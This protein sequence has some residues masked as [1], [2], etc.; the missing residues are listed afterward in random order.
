MALEYGI[1]SGLAV[2]L[3]DQQQ[4]I[5]Y[6][7]NMKRQAKIAAEQKAKMFADD[8]DYNNA[9]NAH[10]NPL[11]KQY[12]MGKLM[13]IGKLIKENPGWETNPFARSR[14]KQ[15]IHDLKDNPA[16][17]RGNIS[18]GNF[19]VMMEFAGNPKN[20][21]IVNSPFW[22]E[23][24][25]EW[26][27]Y[28]EFGNQHGEEGLAKYGKQAFQFNSPESLIDVRQKGLEIG[29]KLG[30]TTQLTKGPGFGASKTFVETKKINDEAINVFRGPDAFHWEFSWDNLS[31]SEKNY[32]GADKIK[33]AS[34]LIKAGTDT[35]VTA[36][37]YIRP[38]NNNDSGNGGGYSA[39][40]HQILRSPTWQVNNSPTVKELSPL[41]NEDGKGNGILSTNEPLRIRA[42]GKNGETYWKT[43]DGF[44]NYPVAATRTNDYMVDG[45]GRVM[46]RFKVKVNLDSDNASEIRNMFDENYW[47]QFGSDRYEEMEAYSNVA[48]LLEDEDGEKTSIAEVDVW[49]PANTSYA[50]QKLYDNSQIGQRQANEAYPGLVGQ[51]ALTQVY[52]RSQLRQKYTD[53]QIDD[54]IK[55]GL[56]VV[57]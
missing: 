31:E 41:L 35:K 37:Q 34:D 4:Q 22:E 57:D 1:K 19:K 48:R 45:N 18:D 12:A 32:Y 30:T 52:S 3:P 21:A 44:K 27:N 40:E 14:Y 26:N 56:N 43:V 33:W 54:A 15:M 17:N 49:A 23:K 20:S 55:Q 50:N 51:Q 28:L 9:M 42:T 6:E 24:I 16:L 7:A 38:N 46:M 8:F 39:Y 2:R 13:E 36:G 25:D 53:A 47:F 5:Y 11:V 29:S 10:D